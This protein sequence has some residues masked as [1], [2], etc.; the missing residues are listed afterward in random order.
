[1][2]GL[3][4]GHAAVRD[5]DCRCKERLCK[6]VHRTVGLKQQSSDALAPF[7]MEHMEIDTEQE[8]IVKIPMSNYANAI[9]TLLEQIYGN[10]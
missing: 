8:C 5:G 9:Y 7:L 3:G 4:W 1:M 2:L 10:I 6:Y